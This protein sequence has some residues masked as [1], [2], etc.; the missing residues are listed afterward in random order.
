M[1]EREAHQIDRR[2]GF[3]RTQRRR[4]PGIVDKLDAGRLVR[5]AHA[6][7][8]LAAVSTEIDD[9]AD[10]DIGDLDA[11]CRKA[12]RRRLTDAGGYHPANFHWRLR[13]RR[14][15]DGNVGHGEGLAQQVETDGA[16]GRGAA[17]R[18]DCRESG[19]DLFLCALLRPQ[20]GAEVATCGEDNEAE[21]TDQNFAHGTRLSRLPIVHGYKS[22]ILR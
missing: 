17:A 19:F 12:A 14:H 9:T 1:L 2:R 10:L 11:A 13:L 20:V 5:D 22:H 7:A 3:H 8:V 21:K 16:M 15:L 6:R 4:G 18:A